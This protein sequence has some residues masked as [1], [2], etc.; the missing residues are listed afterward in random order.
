PFANRTTIDAFGLVT[1]QVG[2]AV[3]NVLLYV[4]GGGAV[5]SDKY[6]GF[7]NLIGATIDS[8][9]DVRWGGVVGVGLEYGF[10]PNWSAAIAYDHLFMGNRTRDFHSA[11]P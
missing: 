3:N 5:V 2:Y 11:V 8:N 1:G 6:T 4:K 7:N 10:T 9:N